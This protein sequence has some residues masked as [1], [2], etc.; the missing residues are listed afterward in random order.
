LIHGGYVRERNGQYDLTGIACQ[1][2][3]TLSAIAGNV[4]EDQAEEGLGIADAF[5][6]KG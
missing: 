5:G 4:V 6:D 3:L 2:L 1:M